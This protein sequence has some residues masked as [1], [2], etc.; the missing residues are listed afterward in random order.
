MIPL[1]PAIAVM[2]YLFF[3]LFV[4]LSIWGMQH[5]RRRKEGSFPL[6]KKLYHCEYCGSIYLDKEQARVTKCPLCHSF[7]SPTPM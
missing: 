1:S 7:N 6:E 4:L 5:F 2:A 3:T